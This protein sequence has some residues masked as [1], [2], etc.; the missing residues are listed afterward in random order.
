ML[1]LQEI[2]DQA[3]EIL[4]D[5]WRVGAMPGRLSAEK[6]QHGIEMAFGP[7]DFSLSIEDLSSRKIG[8][9]M[10]ILAGKLPS[11]I[12]FEELG[13]PVIAKPTPQHLGDVYARIGEFGGVKVR[14]LY[15]EVRA[16]HGEMLGLL[17]FDILVC[18][19]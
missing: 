17:R 16:L 11:D 4:A 10:R 7:E 13:F 15:V 19:A 5:R 12:V 1:S 2:A 18:R 14:A 8:P 9:A 6:I 3:A